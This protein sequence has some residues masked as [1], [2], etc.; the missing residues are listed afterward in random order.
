M[1]SA[2]RLFRDGWRDA[3]EGPPALEEAGR[4]Q[5]VCKPLTPFVVTAGQQVV[6]AELIGGVAGQVEQP[7]LGGEVQGG[8]PAVRDGVRIEME[9]AWPAGAVPA[10]ARFVHAGDGRIGNVQ[11][12]VWE[13]A[14]AGDRLRRRAEA[15]RPVG[16]R[17]Q[18]RLRIPGGARQS[19]LRAIAAADRWGTEWQY[20]S[21]GTDGI[22]APRAQLV[23][24]LDYP[25]RVVRGRL[26]RRTIMRSLLRTRLWNGN[27]ETPL[28]RMLGQPPEENLLRW[29]TRTLHKWAER[30]PRIEAAFPHLAIVRL[31]TPRE[32]ER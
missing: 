18:H 21:K 17:R 24:W 3:V 28:W 32:T 8:D 23:L 31:R 11:P 25:Y 2:P 12:P 1:A 19:G 15:V 16:R 4:P 29:Q 7:Q 6:D 26:L 30:M 22:L 10:E 27:V 14:V 5:A 9:G 13:S 20:T